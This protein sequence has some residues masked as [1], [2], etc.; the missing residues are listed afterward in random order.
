MVTQFFDGESPV[1][2]RITIGEESREIVGVVN[3]IVQSRLTGLLPQSATVYFPMDQRP[4]RTLSIVIRGE[5]DP[6]QLALPLQN[7]VWAVDRDQPI[8]RVRTL[9]AHIRAELAG[10]NVMTQILVIVGVLTLVLAGIGI[11]GVMAYSVTQRTREIGIRMALGA[12]AGQVLTRI[13]RQ[14]A[15]LAGGGLLIGTPLAIAGLMTLTSIFE[16][17]AVQDGLKG[18]GGVVAFAPVAL[19]SAILVGV[20]LTACYLPARRATKVDPVEALQVE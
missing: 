9:E 14:G 5:R 18:S 2:R 3:N 17:A 4:A 19:V 13:V 15:I 7:A 1:G 12:S 6:N 16:R 20:G 11:Y 10:P 8:S